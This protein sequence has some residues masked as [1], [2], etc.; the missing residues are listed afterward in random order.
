MATG[1]SRW[2]LSLRRFGRVGRLLVAVA[3]STTTLL[4][5]TPAPAAW[6][7]LPPELVPRAGGG[8]AARG[9]YPVFY[10]ASESGLSALVATCGDD[11]GPEM[12]WLAAGAEAVPE[13]VAALEVV[14]RVGDRQPQAGVWWVGHT[15]RMLVPE[16]GWALFERLAGEA[17]FEV[18]SRFLFP[19]R[20]RFDIAATAGVVTDLVTA[21]PAGG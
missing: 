15:R 4:A 2:G 6:Q 3:A 18:D 21:C 16:G 19:A 20:E 5:P 14:W 10:L 13:G 7:R 17:L 9:V 11:G 12:F 8:A 1:W